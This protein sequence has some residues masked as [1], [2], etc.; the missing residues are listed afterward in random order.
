MAITALF[1]LAFAY[2]AV[3]QAAVARNTAQA[4]ADAAALAAARESRDELHDP[5]LAALA[6]GDV[7]ALSDLLAK[8]GMDS[9]A[10]C[11]EAM[12][13]AN[14][15]DAAT[16]PGGCTQDAGTN[17]Y[18]VHVKSLESVGRSVVHGTD[19]VYPTAEAT[20]V[21]T[22]RCDAAE[23]DG[24]GVRFRCRDG[25]ITVDPTAANFALD[26][27]QFYAVHLSK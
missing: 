23:P 5:F 19:T 26:L 22:P 11:T 3:G 6:S 8:V 7:G 21:V 25:V 20:A 14:D 12:R 10:A 9:S 15:N 17:G 13:Y 2:F 16:E 24:K 27:S 1:L 4:A 18:T